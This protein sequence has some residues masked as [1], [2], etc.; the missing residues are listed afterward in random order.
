MAELRCWPNC[1]FSLTNRDVMQLSAALPRLEWLDLG[2]SCS[3]N[4]SPGTTV[5]CLL[6]LSVHWKYLRSVWIYFNATNLVDDI[7]FLSED[8]DLRG[9]RELPTRCPLKYFDV[10]SLRFPNVT[11]RV[12]TTI[13]ERFMDIFPSIPTI[14]SIN[15]SGWSMLESRVHKI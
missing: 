4:S 14:T 5:S 11:D 13:A 15:G 12:I 2:L 1:Y 3:L 6:A 10:G 8:P 7:R 9:L